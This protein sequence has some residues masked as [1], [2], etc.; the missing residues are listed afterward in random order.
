MAGSESLRRVVM[1]T[2]WFPQ[3]EHGGYYHALVHGYYR[4]AGFEVEIL[5][6]GVNAQI[7]LKVARGDADFGMNRSDL[8]FVAQERGLP[9]VVVGA[10]LQYDPQALML[11]E[12][13]PVNS[14]AGL[15]GRTIVAA[16]SMVW[17]PYLKK[18]YGIDFNLRPMTY[19]LAGFMADRETIQQC[20]VTN[21]PFFARQHGARVKTLLIADSGYEAYHTIFTRRELL[22]NEPGMVR[23]FVAASMRGWADYLASDP[24]ATHAEIIRRNPQVSSEL[25]DYSRGQMIALRLVTGDEARGDAP[26]RVRRSRLEGQIAALQDADLLPA[27]AAPE[28]FVWP[29]IIAEE[30]V[31]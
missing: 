13:N 14:F 15:D 31:R 28:Q 12:D 3:A 1:Q 24:A 30:P 29:E 26:G 21:E 11:H 25:L 8:L 10:H 27:G 18:Q 23:A 19:S 22:R 17:I 4:E 20:F 9:I 2:D 5:P 6:G 7:N 16:P